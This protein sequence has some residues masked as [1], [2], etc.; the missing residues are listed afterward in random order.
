MQIILKDLRRPVPLPL[1]C[2]SIPDAF[3]VH[4]FRYISRRPPLQS[5]NSPTGVTYIFLLDD[6]KK[7]TLSLTVPTLVTCSYY[8]YQSLAISRAKDDKLFTL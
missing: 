2:K 3:A 4:R 8:F 6:K 5:R 7:F 1:Y